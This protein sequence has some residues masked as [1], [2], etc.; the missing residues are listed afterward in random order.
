[1]R[2][3]DNVP[4]AHVR[5]SGEALEHV[6]PIH[7]GTSEGGPSSRTGSSH[8]SRCIWVWVKIGHKLAATVGPGEAKPNVTKSR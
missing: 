3:E 6:E 1:M 4:P 7:K 8:F 5:K 2:I